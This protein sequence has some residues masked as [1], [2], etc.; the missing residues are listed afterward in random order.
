MRK[1]LL[2]NVGPELRNHS[3]AMLSSTL[4]QDPNLCTY[5]LIFNHPN[6]LILYGTNCYQLKFWTIDLKILIYMVLC[7]NYTKLS[8]IFS[9]GN[10]FDQKEFKIDVKRYFILIDKQVRLLTLGR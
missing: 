9:I 4:V 10:V 6:T 1:W 3:Y 2:Y 8:F 5:S 7:L